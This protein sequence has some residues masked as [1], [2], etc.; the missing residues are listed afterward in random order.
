MA[1]ALAY[2]GGG[3]VVPTGRALSPDFPVTPGAFDNS[4]NGDYDI[5]VTRLPVV[6]RGY[7]PWLAGRQ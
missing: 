2:D 3:R 1:P 7:L 4:H 6:I 5:F